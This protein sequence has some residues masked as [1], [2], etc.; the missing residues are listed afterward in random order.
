MTT[1]S[2]PCLRVVRAA[3]AGGRRGLE[4]LA[5]RGVAVIDRATERGA[6]RIVEAI[7]RHGDRALLESVARFDGVDRLTPASFG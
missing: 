5:R 6:E 7:R 1:H 3:S 2:S 4:R